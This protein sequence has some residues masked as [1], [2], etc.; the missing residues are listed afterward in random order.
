MANVRRAVKADETRT[1]GEVKR[2]DYVAIQWYD[3]FS[4]LSYKLLDHRQLI[5]LNTCHS[6]VGKIAFSK[7]DKKSN[8]HELSAQTHKRIVEEIS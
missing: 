1:K 5:Q 8:R 2:G 4:N 3:K 6:A 7:S